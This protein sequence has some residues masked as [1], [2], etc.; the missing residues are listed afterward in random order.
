MPAC[1]AAAGAGAAAAGAGGGGL[2]LIWLIAWALGM[3]AVSLYYYL[4]VLKQAYVREAE[5]GRG[6][7]A[8]WR[9]LPAT[10]VVLLGLAVAVVLLGC[11]PGG[12]LSWL[13][14]ALGS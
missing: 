1:G 7:S 10:R 5:A 12:V 14:A 4:Q 2:G 3:S 9:V 6:S 11:F 8:A 13:R